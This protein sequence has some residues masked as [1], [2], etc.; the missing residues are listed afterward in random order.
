[1]EL[2]CY[3]DGILGQ[4]VDRRYGKNSTIRCSKWNGGD[5]ETK[6]VS[7]MPNIWLRSFVLFIFGY[8]ATVPLIVLFNAST[9]IM[10]VK[11]KGLKRKDVKYE[12][13]MQEPLRWPTSQGLSTYRSIGNWRMMRGLETGRDWRVPA[14]TCTQKDLVS[15]ARS[16]SQNSGWETS[17]ICKGWTIATTNGAS[18]TSRSLVSTKPPK[19]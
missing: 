13:S 16:R 10:K 9:N 17:S 19:R 3:E 5:L 2:A 8:P 12:N 7:K 18:T 6:R 1:M 4:E 15:W 11:N 14:S